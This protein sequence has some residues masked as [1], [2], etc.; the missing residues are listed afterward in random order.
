MLLAEGAKALA[1]VAEDLAIEILAEFQE[2]DLPHLSKSIRRLQ[3]AE[4]F[5]E[6]VEHPVP[7]AVTDLLTQYRAAQN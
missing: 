5:L 3:N 2:D 6:K 7:P 1:D 4:A